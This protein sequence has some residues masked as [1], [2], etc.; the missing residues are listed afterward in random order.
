MK[1]SLSLILPVFALLAM[2]PFSCTKKSQEIKPRLE[3]AFSPSLIKVSRSYLE[4]VLPNGSMLIYFSDSDC[5]T[6][7]KLKPIVENWSAK[8]HAVV[9]EYSDS[10]NEGSEE[11]RSEMLKKLGSSDGKELTAGRL[12]AFT[13]G[14]R[15]ASIA[16][17]FELESEEKINDFAKKYFTL[18]PAK[19]FTVKESGTVSSMNEL[20][21]MISENKKALFYHS[22]L[23][24]PDCR[25]FSG[26]GKMDAVTWLFQNTKLPFYMI[27][28]E[29]VTQ[30]LK[31]PVIIEG[32]EYESA[33]AYFAS[34]NEDRNS[35]LID[36]NEK[37][38]AEYISMLLILGEIKAFP[39]DDEA[40]F[41]QIAAYSEKTEDDTFKWQFR[42]VP[43]L[44]VTT[45]PDIKIN[46]KNDAEKILQNAYEIAE[47]KNTLP[48]SKFINYFCLDNTK[49]S[50]DD[51]LYH[52]G[53]WLNF[54]NKNL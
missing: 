29:P 5:S 42:F 26:T 38:I 23:S 25:L 10:R 18:P 13:E 37:K 49:V 32:I 36:P 9:Y 33:Y 15:R 17:T 46:L 40:F 48:K 47:D 20:R 28:S 27:L 54:W 7:Q 24:C 45:K 30:S 14:K 52:L 3:T 8:S 6:C 4:S 43:A 51:Y 50:K 44:T 16:G 11:E 22:R 21:T 2:N 19:T 41:K 31:T 35:W 12:I 53:V 34:C 39:N 1:K